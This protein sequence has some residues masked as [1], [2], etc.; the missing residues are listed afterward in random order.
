MSIE[1]EI[2][3]GRRMFAEA[4]SNGNRLVMLIIANEM[5]SLFVKLHELKCPKFK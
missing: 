4:H 3:I 1:D 5:S 2:K